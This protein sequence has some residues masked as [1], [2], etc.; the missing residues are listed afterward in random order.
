MTSPSVNITQVVETVQQAPQGSVAVQSTPVLVST[1][2]D[3]TVTVQATLATITFANSPVTVNV[4][5][6]SV[7]VV[8]VGTQGPQGP[9]GQSGAA[10][11]FQAENRTGSSFLI[12]QPLATHSSGSGVVL[13]SAWSF[14]GACIGVATIGVDPGE[15]ETVQYSGLLSLNDWTAILGT[16]NLAPQAVYYLST[17]AGTLSLTAPTIPGLIVQPVGRA[18]SGTQLELI[19]NQVIQL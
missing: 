17:T 5:N 18:V 4:P 2:D 8:D 11:T 19:P 7:G 10:P 3:G 15:D 16:V 14:G 12:G 6:T 1:A 13:A 9:P